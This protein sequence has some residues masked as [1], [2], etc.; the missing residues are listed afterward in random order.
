MLTPKNGVAIKNTSDWLIV[1]RFLLICH[2]RVVK[3]QFGSL[4]GI[5]SNSWCH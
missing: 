3:L 2:M 4:L 5:S 1:Q